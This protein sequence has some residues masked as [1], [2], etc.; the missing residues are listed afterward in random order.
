MY[1]EVIRGKNMKIIN[2]PSPLDLDK[3][4]V[5]DRRHENLFTTSMVNNWSEVWIELVEVSNFNAMFIMFCAEYT[6]IGAHAKEIVD[7]AKKRVK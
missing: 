6:Q 4:P 2:N 1:L 7:T 5:I 3:I